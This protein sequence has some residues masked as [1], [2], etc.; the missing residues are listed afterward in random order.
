MSQ[1][2]SILVALDGADEGLKRAIT[3]AERSLGELAASAKTAGDK[4]A[5]GIAQVQAGVSVISEQITT[6]RTQLLA[7]L[8]V[9][10]AVGKAQE[11]VQVADAWNMMTAR[12]KLAT[13]GQREFTAAQ[14]ALFDI[15]QRIGVPIQET[16]TL[17]GKLQQAVR[18]L[19]GEQ[20][21]ALN[22]REHLAGAAHLRRVGQ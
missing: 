5:A 11:V 6:A 19:G 10:W 22:Y 17:Y 9:N 21:Q 15:A 4:A 8:S 20:Q 12:L 3:S 16:A 2:I 18:M 14:T 13:A 7:F 1:R